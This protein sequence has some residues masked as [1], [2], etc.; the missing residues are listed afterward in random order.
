MERIN[1]ERFFVFWKMPEKNL[2]IDFCTREIRYYSASH[3]GQARS[4]PA[5]KQRPD[6][7][8]LFI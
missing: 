7:E 1:I 2:K 3:A 4:N 8:A 5:K 6:T